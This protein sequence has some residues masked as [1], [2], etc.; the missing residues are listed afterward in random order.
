MRRGGIMMDLNIDSPLFEHVKVDGN[1]VP[2]L[3]LRGWQEKGAGIRWYVLQNNELEIVLPRKLSL[4]D[5]QY[6]ALK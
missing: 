5:F 1:L 3:K 2:Y 6:Q 4:V